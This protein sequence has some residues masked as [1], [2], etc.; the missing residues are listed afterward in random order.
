MLK[1]RNSKLSTDQL[2]EYSQDTFARQYKMKKNRIVNEMGSLSKIVN[3]IKNDNVLESITEE[4]D[5][6]LE[7]PLITAR[8]TIS[9]LKPD[10]SPHT[11]LPEGTNPKYDSARDTIS[12]IMKDRRV[13]VL[14]TIHEGSGL[15]IPNYNNNHN[16]KQELNYT[17]ATP[18]YYHTYDDLKQRLNLLL[19]SKQA[20]NDSTELKNQAMQI[21]DLL[22]NN[23]VI[24]RDQ[25]SKVYNFL[26][27]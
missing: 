14:P 21:I 23:G 5:R 9:G 12:K 16:Q 8:S 24:N 18:I 4:D 26:L 13:G 22:F 3:E 7:Y 11:Y 15:K 10:K 20:G 25:Y 6:E 27:I 2:N 1:T 17:G 19:A